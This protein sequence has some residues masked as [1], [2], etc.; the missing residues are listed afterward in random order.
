MA[1]ATIRD[2]IKSEIEEIADIGVV[3]SFLR[4][5]K[6]W[7]T[8]LSFYRPTGKNYIRG[9]EITRNTTPEIYDDVNITSRRTYTFLI[10]GY[11]QL[12]DSASSEKTFQGL[13]ED[14]CDKF[15]GNPTLDGAATLS[16]PM[17]IIL[18]DNRPFGSILCHY[19]ELS[20]AITERKSF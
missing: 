4:Y 5:S 17:Q 14:I 19:A 3:H 2:K 16:T 10:K 9:W 18:V 11:G 15:R 20:I 12:D 1:Y 13:L 8:Y 7:A 6:D